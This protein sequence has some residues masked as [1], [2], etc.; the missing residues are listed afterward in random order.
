[1]IRLPTLISTCWDQRPRLLAQLQWARRMIST[2]IFLLAL[3][4]LLE[5][6]LAQIQTIM[7]FMLSPGVSLH[8][9]IRLTSKM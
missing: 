4:D 7:L 8:C 6:A 1:V 5:V 9:C 3:W 2:S